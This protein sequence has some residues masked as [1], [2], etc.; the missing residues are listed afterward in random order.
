MNKEKKDENNSSKKQK[1]KPVVFI[2]K[3]QITLYFDG[4]SNS[5]SKNGG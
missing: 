5:I 4:E 3:F 1:K 2:E